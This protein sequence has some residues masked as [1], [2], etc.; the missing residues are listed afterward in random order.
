MNE[1]HRKYVQEH[2]NKLNAKHWKCAKEMKDES[3]VQKHKKER[4]AKHRIYAQEH[5]DEIRH[6]TCLFKV[7]SMSIID[8]HMPYIVCCTL[9]TI[10]VQ[11]PHLELTVWL[12]I[13]FPLRHNF[14][15]LLEI[16]LGVHIE[17]ICRN[18]TADFAPL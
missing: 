2:K 17:K 14:L 3:N 6:G 13:L 10:L 11:F 4:N 5:K 7:L 9:S 15:H 1:K 18:H 16:L 8:C 12:S